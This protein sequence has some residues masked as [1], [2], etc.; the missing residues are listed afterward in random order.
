MFPFL[1]TGTFKDYT[2]VVALHTGIIYIID[3]S[4]ICPEQKET[5]EGLTIVLIE[6]LPMT[7][8][9]DVPTTKSYVFL[10]CHSKYSEVVFELCKFSYSN[11]VLT[12][13]IDIQG[14]MLLHYEPMFYCSVTG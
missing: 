11:E 6:N 5:T 4:I 9:I 7:F 13:R 2:F 14:E 8:I 12:R 10:M 1:V 3:I